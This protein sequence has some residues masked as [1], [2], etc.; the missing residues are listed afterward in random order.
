LPSNFSGIP[1]FYWK[2]AGA[3]EGA[4]SVTMNN[5]TARVSSVCMLAFRGADATTPINAFSVNSSDQA[6][7]SPVTPSVTTTVA[8]CM[9]LGFIEET[10]GHSATLTVSA[11]T[12]QAANYAT[13]AAFAA[14]YTAPQGAA[15]SYCAGTFSCAETGRTF[16]TISIAIAP[17]ASSGPTIT[18]QPSNQT[19][20]AG[21]TA[22]FTVAATASS[23]SLTYQWQRSTDGGSSYSNVTTGTGGT[24]ASY[25]T[26]PTTV[27]GG[28]ANN[29][30]KYQVIVTDSNGNVTS[31][32]AT[33]TVTSP[34][35]GN[36]PIVVLMF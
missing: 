13:A 5:D 27:S 24:T 7:Q 10:Q 8:G 32:A 33:L 14:G 25:T 1:Y 26:D 12:T 2:I 11:T 31:T 16:R 34:S 22:T 18:T 19:V 23:G 4:A 30:D 17:A 20:T 9:I 36:G 35:S 6:T 21:A 29:G 28:T 15:G 3:S